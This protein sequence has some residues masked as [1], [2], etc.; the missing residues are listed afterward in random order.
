[1]SRWN[2]YDWDLMV[3]KRAPAPLIAA[4]LLLAY[5]VATA[6]SGSVN[7]AR[8]KADHVELIAQIEQNRNAAMVQINAQIEGA[9]SE[10]Q[11]ADLKLLHESV[12]DDEEKHRGQA[13]RIYIDC[14]N[15]ARAGY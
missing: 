3:R 8:C 6:Q 13:Q 2:E 7:S 12:W 9:L 15:A 10:R 14:L 4:A 5:W 1:M 11:I